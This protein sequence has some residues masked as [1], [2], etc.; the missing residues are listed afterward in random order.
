MYRPNG[1]HLVITGQ[2]VYFPTGCEWLLE[3]SGS[4][5]ETELQKL[6]DLSLTTQQ[7]QVL[8]CSRFVSDL[9]MLFDH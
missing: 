3:V 7:P 5:S 6:R 2:K 1:D 4:C 9:R 8:F